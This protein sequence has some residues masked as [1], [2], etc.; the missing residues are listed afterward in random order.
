[1]ALAADGDLMLLHRLQQRGLR[2]RR[3]AVDLVGQDHVGEDRPCRNRSSRRRRLVFLDHFRAGDVRGHQVG[4][5]LDAAEFQRQRVGQRA[6]HKRLGQAR[7]AHQKA[8]PPG[9]HGHQQFFDHLLLPHDHPAQ[10]LGNQA[11]CLV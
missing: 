4:R 6:N 8:M 5:E 10:L 9:E 7:H 2:F 11:V 3:R 1:M